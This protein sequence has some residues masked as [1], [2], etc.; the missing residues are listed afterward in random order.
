MPAN[1]KTGDEGIAV[2][3]KLIVNDKGTER[4]LGDEVSA[5]GIGGSL[6]RKI[7][8]DR[9][10]RCPVVSSKDGSALEPTSRPGPALRTPASV[11]DGFVRWAIG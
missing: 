4:V 11:H 10:V 9:P 1:L 3:C 5:P 8:G 6:L 2:H 7:G